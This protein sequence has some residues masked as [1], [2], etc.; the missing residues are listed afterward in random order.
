MLGYSNCAID[1]E[2]SN[3]YQSTQRLVL[4]YSNRFVTV[5][6][7]DA[8]CMY[9]TARECGL[10][11]SVFTYRSI[12]S[13]E[14]VGVLDWSLGFRWDSLTDEQRSKLTHISD[15]MPTPAMAGGLFTISRDYF[16]EVRRVISVAF[17]L[18]C[19]WVGRGAMNDRIAS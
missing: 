1:Q 19:G 14:A 18:L 3:P 4:G 16:Y 17:D 7:R 8:P 10:I 9:Q 11:N 6:A 5:L 15:P 13:N 12:A 2:R